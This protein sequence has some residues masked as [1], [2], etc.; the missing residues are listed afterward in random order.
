MVQYCAKGFHPR[1]FKLSSLKTLSLVALLSVFFGSCLTLDYFQSV[2]KQLLDVYYMQIIATDV[3]Q[4]QAFHILLF[5]I[6]PSS[7]LLLS[8]RHTCFFG[9]DL[10]RVGQGELEFNFKSF[11]SKDI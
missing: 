10:N 1:E 3:S 8:N 2:G 11:I 6:S 5:Y 9:I 7:Y 4:F